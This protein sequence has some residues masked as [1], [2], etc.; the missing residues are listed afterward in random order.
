MFVVIAFLSL[1]LSLELLSHTRP[2]TPGITHLE[3][4][5]EQTMGEPGIF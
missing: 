5:A 2:T 1:S 4:T 3:L